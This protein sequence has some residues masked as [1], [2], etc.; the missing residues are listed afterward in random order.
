MKRIT[1][2]VGVLLGLMA[3]GA[4]ASFIINLSFSGFTAGRRQYAWKV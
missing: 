1:A 3:G 2:I 4:Q